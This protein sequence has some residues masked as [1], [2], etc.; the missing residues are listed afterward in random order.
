MRRIRARRP[1][2]ACAV[3]LAALAAGACGTGTR[4]APSATT[5]PPAPRIDVAPDV[6]AARSVPVVGATPVEEDAI[7]ATLTA[8]G[9]PSPVAKVD[10][11]ET[12]LRIAMQPP[13]AV[14][15]PAM[16]APDV[17]AALGQA[18]GT[19]MLDR[20]RE[21]GAGRRRLTVVAG[22]LKA[23]GTRFGNG[24]GAPAGFAAAA[25]AAVAA[26]EQAGFRTAWARAYPVAGGVLVA[27]IPRT[28]VE[29]LV[30]RTDWASAFAGVRLVAAT[31]APDGTVV[32]SVGVGARYAAAA[33]GQPAGEPVG[34]SGPTR[35]AIELEQRPLTGPRLARSLVLDCD[36]GASTGVAD[37]AAACAELVARRYALLARSVS[38]TTCA[39]GLG[40]GPTVRLAGTFRGLPV[41]RDYGECTRDVAGAWFDLLGVAPLPG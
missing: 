10:L 22:S 30:G 27:A 34:L 16:S 6:D 25:R 2:L 14:G 28:E 37:A 40:T 9:A 5:T 4:A 13:E 29:L 15:A 36:G 20:L 7:R 39:G 32:A 24:H 11:T 41:V 26:G 17:M 3:A 12:R 31:I 8:L 1:A 23:G 38:D 19:D 18:V 35:L 21:A 33:S